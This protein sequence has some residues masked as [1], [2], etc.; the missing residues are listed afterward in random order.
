MGGSQRDRPQ[1][2]EAFKD[3]SGQRC[4]LGGVGAGAQ[5]VQQHQRSVV[6]D[7]QQLDYIPNMSRK[8]RKTLLD[9]LFI[10]DID[11]HMVKNRYLAALGGG[12]HHAAGRHQAEQADRFERDRLTAGIGAGHDQHTVILA[13]GDVDGYNFIPGNER[14]TRLDKADA[15]VLAD[16]GDRTV[17]GDS[18]PRLGQTDVDVNNSLGADAQPIGEGRHLGRELIEDAL[19]LGR[20]LAL[21][22]DDGIVGLDNGLRLYEIGRSA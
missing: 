9:A 21:E 20:L 16:G 5:L 15:A 11:Q 6:S 1:P 12:D 7:G 13:D 10:A 22:G 3:G 18:E 19:D 2:A 14:V 17:I 4:A 8:G